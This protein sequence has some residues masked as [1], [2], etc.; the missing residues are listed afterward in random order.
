MKTL[1]CLSV[2]VSLLGAT[3]VLAQSSGIDIG[4]ANDPWTSH[5]NCNCL[6]KDSLGTAGTA[7]SAAAAST[8]AGAPQFTDTFSGGGTSSTG[9]TDTLKPSS[10]P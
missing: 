5:Q 10:S 2:V 6:W 1:A 9:V 8:P 7:P 4:V 3:P